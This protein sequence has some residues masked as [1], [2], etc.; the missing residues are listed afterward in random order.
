MT[1][2]DVAG[3]T[4]G[5]INGNPR[6]SVSCYPRSAQRVAIAT[7][8]SIALIVGGCAW[9]VAANPPNQEYMRA[10]VNEIATLLIE[11]VGDVP[12]GNWTFASGQ[13]GYWER[14]SFRT[15]RLRNPDASVRTWDRKFFDW[16]IPGRARWAQWGVNF[17][18]DPVAFD[19]SNGIAPSI[20]A[21]K[22]RHQLTK[23]G[24]SGGLLRQEG[25]ANARSVTSFYLD[26]HAGRWTVSI[27][28]DTSD[29]PDGEI[30]ILVRSPETNW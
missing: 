8:V 1:N 29:G 27:E 26:D 3:A 17:L 5:S 10:R 24:W 2:E 19:P 15:I 14:D 9:W 25:M 21:D 12:V 13:G 16:H 18:V 30:R 6:E 20:I 4:Q 22:M 23:R 7:L 11:Q 28:N